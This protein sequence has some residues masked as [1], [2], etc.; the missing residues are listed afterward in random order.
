[1]DRGPT[2]EQLMAEMAWGRRLDRALVRDD[3][4]ADDVA[5]DTWLVAETHEPPANAPLRP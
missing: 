3:T 1:M 2:T 4:L 5:Q